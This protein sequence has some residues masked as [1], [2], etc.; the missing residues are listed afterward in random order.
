MNRP[1]NTKRESPE[2]IEELE[3]DR[4]RLDKLEKHIISWP[5]R[6][7]MVYEIR[8]EIPNKNDISLRQAIDNM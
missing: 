8:F 5:I 2:Y 1:A 6:W 3:K 4:E 7:G